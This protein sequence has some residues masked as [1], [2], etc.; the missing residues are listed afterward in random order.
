M[1]RF[2]RFLVVALLAVPA[3]AQTAV[4]TTAPRAQAPRAADGAPALAT[5]AGSELNF[6]ISSDASFDQHKGSAFRASAKYQINRHVLVEPYFVYW[7]VDDSEVNYATATYTVNGITAQ[8]QLGFLEP[9]NT[10]REVGV[11]IGFR[12]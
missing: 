8:Q 4:S 2:K 3:S 5:P 11:K 1:I 10:T 12:F 6:G 7:R 9:L